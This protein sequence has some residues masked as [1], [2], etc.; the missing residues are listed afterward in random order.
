MKGNEKEK[1][2]LRAIENQ[3]WLESIAHILEHEGPERAR[4]ILE[5]Q[6]MRIREEGA[7]MV[8]GWDESYLN[9]IPASKEEPYPGDRKIERRIKSLVRWNAM[10]MVV[11]ANRRSEGIGGHI[12]TYASSATL[13]EVGFNHFFRAASDGQPADIVYYQGH[14]SP[15]MYARSFLEGRF[16]EEQLNNFRRELAPG[17]G[18]SSYPHPRLMNDYWQFPTVSM[19]LSPIMSIYE[20]RYIKYL[21]DRSRLEPGDQKVW[22]FLGDGEMDEPESMGALTLASR[23]ELDNLIFVI[24]C[25]LQRLDGPV[26]GN[27]S[28]VNELARAF[29]G[30][31]W[32]VIKVLWGE[33]WD[34]LLEKDR[35]GLLKKRL[36]EIVDGQRQKYSASDGSY[37]R[38]DFFGKYDE[39][40]EL[41]EDMSDDEIV[42]LR[43]GGHDPLKVYNAYKA[44]TGHTG[45]PTVILA[46]TIKGYGLGE[47][48]E[49]R[50]VTHQQKKLNE[51]ELKHFRQRFDVPISDEKVA[52]APF[53]KPDEESEEIRYLKERREK[54][55]GAVP[56][57][58]KENPSFEMP[59]PSLFGEFHTGSD[60]REV[61]TT[62]VAI[63]ML[64]KLLKDKN[65]GDMVVP[66]VP[67]ESRTFGMEALFKQAG[68]YAHAGQLY[69]P[70][71]K[72]SLLYYK[73]EQKGV[74]LEEGISEAGCMSSFI[75]A[76]TSYSA[77]GIHSIPVFTFYSMFGFQRIGD[78]IWAAADAR[79]RGFMFG[80]TAGRT[81][82][83]GEGLQH[84]DGNSHLLAITVPC[85]RAY[86]PAYAYEMAVIVEEGM[87]RMY[88]EGH[89]EIYYITMMNEKY[90]MPAMPK[91]KE[92]RKGILKG[93]YRFRSSRKNEH[94]LHLMGSGTILNEVIRASEILKDDY[95]IGSDIWSVTSYKQLY[96]NAVYVNRQRRLEP[97]KKISSHI[98]NCV[99]EDPGVFVAA[100]D[101]VKALPLMVS[102]WFPGPLTALGT[103][104]F[105]LSEDREHLREHFEVSAKHIV[106]SALSSL[107]RSGKFSKKELD[108]AGKKMN[109]VSDKSSAYTCEPTFKK[110]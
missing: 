51:E 2:E 95:G 96:D 47:A 90:P 14:A 101:Y 9:T 40:L 22:A 53:Y 68:I 27:G 67:D 44:A 106:W 73:E 18:L 60:K 3:E 64:S 23:E 104:G 93:M 70:V 78:L 50:N 36:G 74:I 85:V 15:G 107:H 98:E 46:Q 65:V 35:S 80:G 58:K 82:L 99:G 12:S 86:D 71:D 42:N 97:G 37:I 24:N 77:L 4:E 10:A 91:R 8:A 79:A 89:D 28:V 92:V 62:M 21:E 7:D 31:G 11:Q 30:A 34:P 26:R 38:K 5:L 81:T 29:R 13:Y 17:G 54:L 63:R 20:A 56:V 55:G 25:N 72:E 88:E 32:N 108:K 41:V 49:G 66:I 39:L 105:G 59:D 52:E 75:A 19:G 84:Q 61:A 103:D 43:R 110:K 100:S 102:D 33:N 1:N 45:S 57:R 48:G 69:E 6:L 76:G 109:M 83:A 87:R 16:S 94:N